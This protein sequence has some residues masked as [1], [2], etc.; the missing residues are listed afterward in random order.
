MPGAEY[1]VSFFYSAGSAMQTGMG[2]V[3]LTW[4]EIDAWARR[5]GYNHSLSPFEAETIRKMSEAYAVQYAKASQR[6]CPQPFSPRVD[7]DE[8][9]R[10]AVSRKV[11]NVLGMF[12]KK[13]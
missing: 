3:P 1:L 9:D 5:C 6:I 8:L 7:L 4:Q 13:E 10:E 11:A 2:L 12:K